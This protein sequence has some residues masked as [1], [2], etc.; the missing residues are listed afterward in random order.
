M[1]LGDMGKPF[2]FVYKGQEIKL[3]DKSEKAEFDKK[4]DKFLK[5]LADAKAKLK[6]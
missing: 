6:K 2:V 4:P 3:C 1:K 5:K